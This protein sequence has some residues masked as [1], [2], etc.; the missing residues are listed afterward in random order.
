VIYTPKHPDFQAI[1]SSFIKQYGAKKGEQVYYAWLNKHSYDDTKAFPSESVTWAIVSKWAKE[2]FKVFE[3]VKE[4]FEWLTEKPKM[5]ADEHGIRL[6]KVRCINVTT[7]DNLNTYVSEELRRAARTLI[8]KPINLNHS[9][10]NLQGVNIVK[11]AEYN[12]NALEAIIQV[13]DP[14]VNRLYD[15]G[16]IHH[17]SIE[18]DYRYAMHLNSGLLPLGLILQGYAFLSDDV[19][20]GDTGSNVQL[21]EKR[22][23][24]VFA[25]ITEHN[26]RVTMLTEAKKKKE[27]ETV[28]RVGQ[29]RV[30]P[31]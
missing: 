19:R 9:V 23:D 14:T 26:R 30:Q 24:S 29:K 1:L 11:D 10:Y 4:S 22:R 7:S 15:E 3:S 5:E 31:S 6:Y 21:W 27:L 13:S 16:K 25:T 20:P 2:G 28:F 8:G 18:A 12:D 17:G